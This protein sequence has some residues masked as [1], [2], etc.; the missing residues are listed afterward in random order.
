MKTQIIPIE[1]ASEETVMDLIANGILYVD[2]E[3]LHVTEKQ[4][5]ALQT[6]DL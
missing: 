1:R 3:G 6:G 5:P 2:E 4:A